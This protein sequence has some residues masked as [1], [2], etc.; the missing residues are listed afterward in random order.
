[1]IDII[2]KSIFITYTI[3]ITIAYFKQRKM[4]RQ[5][6]I[7]SAKLVYSVQEM[8]EEL[9]EQLEDVKEEVENNLQ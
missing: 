8:V 9:N 3:G 7:E 4:C 2:L 5:L 6:Y 1:M